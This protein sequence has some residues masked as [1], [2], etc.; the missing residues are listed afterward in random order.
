MRLMLQ[1][2]MSLMSLE[3]LAIPIKLSAI[4]SNYDSVA[5]TTNKLVT[6]QLE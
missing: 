6:T 5:K 2:R 3:A 1:T 4:A